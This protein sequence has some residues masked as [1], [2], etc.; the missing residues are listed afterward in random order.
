MKPFFYIY[1]KFCKF[2]IRDGY[3]DSDKIKEI[4]EIFKDKTSSDEISSKYFIILKIIFVKK[5]FNF[6][7][8]Y[9]QMC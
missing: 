6:K 7:Y 2:I 8:Y 3:V 1:F 9:Y 5:K 4:F